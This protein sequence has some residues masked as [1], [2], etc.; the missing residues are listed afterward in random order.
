MGVE[1]QTEEDARVLLAETV[2][3]LE[4]A[5]LLEATAKVCE[6]DD[7]HATNLFVDNNKSSDFIDRNGKSPRAMSLLKV[8]TIS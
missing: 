4:K 6:S 1:D 8:Q 3:L 7:E 2:M 5:A